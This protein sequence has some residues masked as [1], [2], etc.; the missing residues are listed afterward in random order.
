MN[1][2]V[3]ELRSALE[4]SI[5][6]E[7]AQ[8]TVDES[9]S[10][11][12]YKCYLKIAIAKRCRLHKLIRQRFALALK[13]QQE[14]F[15]LIFQQSQATVDSVA[16]Q[17]FPVAVFVHPVASNSSIQSRAYMYQLLLFIQST[18]YPG[19]KN[20]RSSKAQQLKNKS[21]AKQLT[22]YE[23]LSSRMSTAELNSNG[24]NDK[25]PAKEKDATRRQNAVVPTYSNDIVLLSPTPNS[26]DWLKLSADCH[27]RKILRLILSAKAK[28]C[29]TNLFE[30]HR[31]AI[32]NFK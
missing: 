24:E 22:T 5:E 12:D 31:F 26:I 4:K 16:T 8:V 30:R 17:R 2:L 27:H 23:E 7:D 9:V 10:S 1:Q 19:A 32:A 3:L 18:W 20:C 11:S 14:D 29:R 21:A 13:I 25:K 15:A 6:E 28:R